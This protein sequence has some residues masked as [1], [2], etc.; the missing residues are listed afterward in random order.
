M[1]NWDKI[2]LFR[3]KIFAPYI[4][5]F[6]KG[7]EFITSVM[8]L[9]FLTALVLQYGFNLSTSTTKY[10]DI[11]YNLTWIIYLINV[12]YYI[13]IGFNYVRKKHKKLIIILSLLLYSS[14]IPHIFFDIPKDSSYFKVLWD[15]L[16]GNFYK[17]ILLTI[18]S[19]F[20]CS[21]TIVKLLGKK[22]N[23]SL[24]L[25][26]SFFTII[27]IGT[28]LLLLPRSTYDGIS[29]IN[30]FFISTSAVCVTGL[31]TV[32]V[33]H[34]F[35]TEGL[36]IIALL[37]QIGGIGVMTL[38]S[39]F[40]V[41]FMGNTSVYNQM[42]VKDMVNSD[43]LSTLIQTLVYILLFTLVIEF[44][45]MMFI[46]WSIHG[47]LNM[48]IKGELFFS[49]FHAISSFCNAGFSTLSG[50]LGNPLIM[51]NHNFFLNIISFLI[52]LGGIGFPIL[53]NFK[54]IV[55]GKS[56]YRLLNLNTKIVIYTT[57]ILLIG[58]TIL[59]A[60]FEWNGAFSGMS[61]GSKITQA[62]FNAVCPRTAG[63]NTIDLTTLSIQSALIYIILM[64]IG[65]ASQSTAGG[66]KVN[67]FA[68]GFL[69]LKSV[70][71][72]TD[73]VETYGREVSQDSIRRA[74]ATIMLS[75]TI[76]C[77]F[78]F[79]LSITEKGVEPFRIVFECI[80]ALSTVGSS[81]DLTPHLTDIGK[82]CIA[83]LMFIGRVGFITFLLGIIKA[84][85]NNSYKYPIDNI[86]IN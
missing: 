49:A 15:F 44:I 38:T 8:G 29:L 54:D 43:S 19:I 26:V 79:I 14:L 4:T 32:D 57:F 77:M 64:W 56:K 27:V 46:W 41:F 72:N 59:I 22:A 62:F 35:T 10:I 58:G 53:V 23:P 83:I 50:N 81:L 82:V 86:I 51:T 31:T 9:I 66:I 28:G 33:A 47:T 2:I 63:F 37:I 71:K 45:G 80:S 18:Y 1:I 39:F 52:I 70:L 42:V 69:N 76:I 5:I 84:K 74:N 16:G 78:V 11:I 21:S 65:G 6:N 17:G 7:L 36:V 30:A 67:T 34:T 40:A 12:T 25:A 13:I 61:V 73:R 85:K 60:F 3:K 68:V 24:I 75:I 55:L 48:D 20:I